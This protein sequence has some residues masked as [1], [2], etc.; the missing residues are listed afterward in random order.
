MKII[1]EPSE[2]LSPALQ[3]VLQRRLEDD[4]PGAVVFIWPHQIYFALACV[5]CT[6]RDI[7]SFIEILS[8]A[9]L[10]GNFYISCIL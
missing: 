6:S 9:C 2:Q 5:E 3:H 7:S 1:F 8:G 10:A 4:F